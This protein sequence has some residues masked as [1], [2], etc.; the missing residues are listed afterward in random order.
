MLSAFFQNAG[1]SGNE[2][3]AIVGAFQLKEFGKEEYFAEEGKTSRH[4]G[5]IESGMFQYFTLRDGEEKTTYISTENT[6][7][8][9]L[10]SYL[11]EE[12]SREYLRALSKSRVWIIQKKDVT[13]LLSRIPAFKDF[14]LGLLEWQ[15]C[16]IEKSRFD[17]I[18]L[19][20]EQRYEKMLREEPHLLQQI[21][22]QYLASI[23][24]VTPR[25]LSRIRKNNR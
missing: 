18:M 23:L 16:C 24:G 20:A 11:N 22:L 4:L 1:F 12:P 3:D 13:E 10:L 8:A 21:P 25:H 19:S 5:F 2:L 15:I 7:I 9:S 6:F 17:L 14:Y